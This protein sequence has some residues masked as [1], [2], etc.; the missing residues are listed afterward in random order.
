MINRNVDKPVPAFTGVSV[1]F[2]V[3]STGEIASGAAINGE[4]VDRL[5]QVFASTPQVGKSDFAQVAK[6]FA[7]AWTTVG[8][9]EA[10]QQVLI[11]CK[12]QHGDSSGG[13]DMADLSTQEN[14]VQ[15]VY[16]STA[17]SS[18][19]L[20]WSTAAKR[21]HSNVSDY[22]ISSAKRFLRPV[23]TVTIGF[24]ATS[25]VA[26]AGSL[27]QVVQGINFDEF[28]YSPPSTLSF[29]TATATA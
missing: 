28:T 1:V 8:S 5:G 24:A 25:T 17:Y 12:L 21:M 22:Q 6:P 2:P 26:G 20:A 11:D 19:F 27:I 16:Y 4:V 18:V 3:N 7:W 29:T 9:T 13:G 23:T 14:A 15:R 10:N